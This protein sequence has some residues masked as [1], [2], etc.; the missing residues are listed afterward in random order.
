MHISW[1]SD[2]MSAASVIVMKQVENSADNTD[3]IQSDA[4]ACWNRA[5]SATSL[6][7]F[8][9]MPASSF[10]AGSTAAAAHCPHRCPYHTVARPPVAPVPSDL[11]AAFCQACRVKLP[12]YSLAHQRSLTLGSQHY[13]C[14]GCIHVHAAS[15]SPQG[16]QRQPWTVSLLPSW[17]VCSWCASYTSVTDEWRCAI[18]GHRPLQCDFSFDFL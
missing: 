3:V 10:Q 11:T 16:G 15:A 9:W 2:I 4:R 1:L 12:I 18:Q 14:T 13:N 17:D 7:S 5:L 8:P 6:I